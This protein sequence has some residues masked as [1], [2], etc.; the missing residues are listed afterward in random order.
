MGTENGLLDTAQINVDLAARRLGLG[1]DTLEVLQNPEREITVY[2]PL[3]GADGRVR[4]FPG[5]RV[6][7]S[8]VR[9]P[10]KGGIRYHP[11]VTLEETRA[12]AA[13]MTWKCAVVN[14][15][16]GGGKG[17]IR[18]DPTVMTAWELEELTR[19]FT[20][21]VMPLIGVEKDIPAPDVNTSSLVMAWIMDSADEV[22]G[23][24]NPGI[25]TGKP[26]GLWGSLGR[27]EA[28]S[29]G[30][31]VMVREVLRDRGAS[32]E[33]TTVAVQGFGKVGGIAARLLAEAGY[34]VVAVSDVSGGVFRGE[35]LDMREVSA[36]VAQNP[37]HLLAG[38]HG[39]GVERLSNEELLELDV[40]V[41]IP[42]ALEH[43]IKEDNAGRVRAGVVVEGANGP[44]TAAA[45]RILTEKGI[46]VIPDILANAGGVVV[47]YFEWV[48][49]IQGFFWDVEEV[50]ARLEAT[51]QS[52]LR[53]VAGRAR[54]WGV[55]LRTSAYM[56]AL[57]RVVE[58]MQ[59]RGLLRSA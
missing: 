33:E 58:T 25:V 29:R 59:T 40:S 3:V 14:I 45:D 2:V 53:E 13:L 1:E 51:M 47:S 23:E 44:T 12:L 19:R 54:A 57:S 55:S 50:N 15:P 28:T 6:Q 48:Q 5:H 22:T 20:R 49:D 34:R 7:H 16:Y 41:L 56:L 32:P 10:C 35:G 24:A 36:Y 27:E 26:V 42:A 30:L 52:A 46:L 21:M 18:C 8:S 4:V 17:G 38:Y 37:A 9:G 39:P 31:V 43:Q 11:A